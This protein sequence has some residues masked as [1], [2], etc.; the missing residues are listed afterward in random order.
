L[1]I[2]WRKVDVLIDTKQPKQYD[3]AVPL[4]EDLRD[5][6]KMEQTSAKFLFK[7]SELYREAA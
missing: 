4:L 3:E 6:A 5:L 2:L 1:R 7:M